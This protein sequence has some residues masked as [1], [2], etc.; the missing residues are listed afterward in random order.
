MATTEISRTIHAPIET[1]WP[2]LADFGQTHRWNPEVAHSASVGDLAT[3]LGAQRS[4]EFDDTGSKWITEE[5]V[6][7]D[8]PGHRY[9]VQ[10]IGGPSKPPIEEVLV[11]IKAVATTPE[12]TTVT[13]AAT[14]NGRGPL[15]KAMATMGVAAMKRV[16]GRVLHGLDHH[17]TT[18]EVVTT[19]RQ[20]R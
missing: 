11:D 17:V 19:R 16:L 20:L 6:A 18:G 4:C 1:V 7:F 8:E 14:L 9:T 3:G 12:T 5:I 10:L 13:M 15:Q 2:I